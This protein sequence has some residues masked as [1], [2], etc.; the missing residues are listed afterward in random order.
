MKGVFQQL[1]VRERQWSSHPRH[2]CLRVRR[3]I[4]LLCQKWSYDCK[5]RRRVK[6]GLKFFK[7]LW[8]SFSNEF[9]IQIVS[10]ET[11]FSYNRYHRATEWDHHHFAYNVQCLISLRVICGLPKINPLAS[12][13]ENAHKNL[14]NFANIY[15]CL[16]YSYC[17]ACFICLNSTQHI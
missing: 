3:K 16:F 5:G 9:L 11:Y 13:L 10:M 17:C 12:A 6:F 4:S 2:E 1:F 7:K 14:L 15:F 8:F